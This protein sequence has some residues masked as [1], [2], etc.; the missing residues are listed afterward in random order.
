MYA[1]MVLRSK[2]RGSPAA[3]VG[4]CPVDRDRQAQRER[5]VEAV[6]EHDRGLR[7]LAYR[8]LGDRDE[9]DDV[10][11]ESY[12]RAYRNLEAFRGDAALG[13]WLYRITYNACMDRLRASRRERAFSLEECDDHPRDTV[14]DDDPATVSERRVDLASALAALAPE[15][16]AAVILVDVQGYDY[17]T[18]ADILG[19]PAGTLASRLHSARA[20][21]RRSL[22]L[23][24]RPS[25][26]RREQR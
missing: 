23:E 24:S 18:T 15:Q 5:F 26:A 4:G 19:I 9:M 17:A 12:L 13:T 16:R 7:A 25:A 14:W 1:T 2:Q 10:L 8:L 20:I 6:R 3:W 21:L 11:Q 22:D